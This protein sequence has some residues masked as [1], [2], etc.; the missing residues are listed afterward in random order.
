MDERLL[1]GLVMLAILPIH[2]WVVRP[3]GA[4]VERAMKRLAPWG[5]TRRREDVPVSPRGRFF[6]WDIVMSVVWAAAALSLIF[7]GIVST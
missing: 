4:R 2:W 6:V 5:K 1:A 7:R 3:V